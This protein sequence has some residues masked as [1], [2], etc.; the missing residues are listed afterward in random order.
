MTFLRSDFFKK[1]VEG[2]TDAELYLLKYEYMLDP[3][4]IKLV[5]GLVERTGAQV[6]AST[7]YRTRYSLE[8]L[9]QMLA[10]RGATFQ[11]SRKAPRLLPKKFSL[12]VDRGNEIQ[13]FLDSLP[14]RAEGIVILDDNNN[15]VHLTKYLVLTS[16]FLGLRPEHVE[17]A[18]K[19]LN[20][21]Q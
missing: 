1:S 9:N 12:S 2:L 6:I 18:I 20:G 21:E 14:E 13:A 10:N 17:A 15:M 19:I 7:S 8:E 16:N 5:N 4:A 11:L 3:Q